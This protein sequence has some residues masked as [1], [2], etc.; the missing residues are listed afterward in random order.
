MPG[1]LAT[2]EAKVRRI[3]FEAN[4]GQKVCEDPSQ[5]LN[6]VVCVYHLSYSREHKYDCGP[7]Q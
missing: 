2:L 7:G 4:P 1:I 3:R 6:M 5:K